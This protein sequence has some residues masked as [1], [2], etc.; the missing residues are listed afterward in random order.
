MRGDWGNPIAYSSVRE[1]DSASCWLRR[2]R[3]TSTSI[4]SFC[5]WR[6]ERSKTTSSLLFM[7]AVIENLVFVAMSVFGVISSILWI[8]LLGNRIFH[9]W[10]MRVLSCLISPI[11]FPSGSI[12]SMES[13]ALERRSRNA[14]RNLQDNADGIV[15]L[16]CYECGKRCW[17]RRT[18]KAMKNALDRPKL[19]IL[20]REF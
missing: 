9:C 8:G 18:H 5:F 4:S 3:K 14:Q 16:N 7:M 20:R 15:L 2:V 19:L 11:S 12:R 13:F 10:I 6:D 1:A 17:C